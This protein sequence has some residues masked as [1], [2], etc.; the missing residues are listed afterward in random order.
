[1]FFSFL[2][3]T[4]RK[5]MESYD[6]IFGKIGSYIAEDP[7]LSQAHELYVARWFDGS[8]EILSQMDEGDQSIL[9]LQCLSSFIYEYALTSGLSVLDYIL[10]NG[11]GFTGGE[12]RGIKKM[13]KSFYGAFE[14]IDVV[15]GASIRI[16][17][18]QNGKYYEI[19]EEIGSHD[20]EP[21]N[22][23]FARLM[24]NMDRYLVIQPD[25]IFQNPDIYFVKRTLARYAETLKKEG[26]TSLF[27]HEKIQMPTRIDSERAFVE[28]IN[29]PKRIK[30]IF[31][32]IYGKKFKMRDIEAELL[33]IDFK[34]GFH[35]ILKKYLE[36]FA[37]KLPSYEQKKAS[38]DFLALLPDATDHLKDHGEA[39]EAAKKLFEEW[40]EKPQEELDFLAPYEVILQERRINGNPNKRI[41]S[42]F[43][44]A[45]I[46][47]NRDNAR[48]QREY[49]REKV[50]ASK[51]VESGDHKSA[52]HLYKKM[53]EKDTSNYID[54]FNIGYCYFMLGDIDSA[55]KY[56]QNALA[57]KKDYRLAINLLLVINK[58][59]VFGF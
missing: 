40:L 5:F 23:F 9:F 35:P 19:K 42:N 34:D 59:D 13:T 31:K 27:F 39:E 37:E 8:E 44:R 33:K 38:E 4:Q 49:D 47:E 36:L 18:I 3:R 55:R 16:K 57:L 46:G 2:K 52:I 29:L 51:F 54:T 17:D 6:Q 45:L 32:K 56:V 58:I 7:I 14:V 43:S 15:K 1:M 12:K 50:Q 41:V 24:W 30:N 21:G 20:L 53:V 26:L 11:K 10:A 22:L 48:L 28:N 25:G